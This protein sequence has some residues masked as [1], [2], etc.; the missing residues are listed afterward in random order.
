M[1]AARGGALRAHLRGLAPALALLPAMLRER[2]V[3]R[4]GAVVPIEAVVDD[5]PWRGPQ[6]GGH[7]RAGF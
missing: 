4:A 2:R 5:R 1:A 3:L 7:P 6:A